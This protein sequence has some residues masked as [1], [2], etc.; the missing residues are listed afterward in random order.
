MTNL[1]ELKIPNLM[2]KIVI[3]LITVTVAFSACKKEKPAPTPPTNKELLTKAWKVNEAY[4]NGQLSSDP[5]WSSF[6]IT[7][8]TDGTYTSAF[9]TGNGSG[10]WEFNSDQSRVILNKGTADEETMEI[11]KLDEST[12]NMK[13][14]DGT[15]TLEL[16]M[17]P[18]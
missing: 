16:F 14:T 8:K 13:E 5:S 6:R 10:V 18:A 7:F 9:G 2:K 17:I 11:K 4:V 1:G 3:L 15:D 12:F